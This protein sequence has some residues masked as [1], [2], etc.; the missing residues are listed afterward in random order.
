[1]YMLTICLLY[2]HI[3]LLVE[4]RFH[5]LECERVLVHFMLPRVDEVLELP[6]HEEHLV[7]QVPAVLE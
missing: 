7:V 4:V 1:M 2:A 5:L 6:P 3:Q